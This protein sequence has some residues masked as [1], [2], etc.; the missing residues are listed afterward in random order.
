MYEETE[1]KTYSAI[2]ISLTNL[3]YEGLGDVIQNETR[4]QKVLL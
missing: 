1:A 4:S 2:F 3:L